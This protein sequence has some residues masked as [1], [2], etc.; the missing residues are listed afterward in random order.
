MKYK[1]VAKLI[2][3]IEDSGW[4]LSKEREFTETLFVGR[5]NYFLVVFSLFVTAGFANS[6]KTG[7]SLVFYSGAIV[8]LMCWMPLFRALKQFNNI[9]SILFNNK[10]DHPVYILQKILKE[11]GFKSK[12]EIS[13]WMGIYIPIVCIVL[14]LIF[15]LFIDINII[16]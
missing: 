11:K 3:H 12:L 5:F 10:K 1:K 16:T 9:I 7:R 8:L 14:L 2:D 13:R 4:T 6:F 15:G